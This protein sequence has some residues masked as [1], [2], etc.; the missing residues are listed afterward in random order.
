MANPTIFQCAEN[1]WTIVASGVTTGYIYNMTPNVE[2][3]QTYREV[4]NL[5]PSVDEDAYPAF[6]YGQHYERIKH[7]TSIDVYMMAR[8]TPGVVRVDV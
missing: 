5:P 1:T 4:G 8:E 7:A 3:L 6:V 2:F